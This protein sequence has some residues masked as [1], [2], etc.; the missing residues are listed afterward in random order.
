M[1]E[2]RP[3]IGPVVVGLDGSDASRSAFRVAL[4]EAAAME[5]TLKAVHVYS[6]PATTIYQAVRVDMADLEQLAHEWLDAEL[7]SLDADLDPGELDR[8]TPVVQPGHAGAALVDE[9]EDAELLVVGAR[10]LGG[11]RG[12]VAGSVSTFCLHHL[13]CKLLVVPAPPDDPSLADETAPATPS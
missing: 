9:A 3:T 1:T 12:L 4:R 8:V 2:T 5:T 10:G 6:Y 13:P 7:H 11:V